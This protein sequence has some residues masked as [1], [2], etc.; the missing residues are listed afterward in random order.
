MYHCLNAYQ[1]EHSHGKVVLADLN[2][3]D[4]FRVSFGPCIPWLL[5]AFTTLGTPEGSE[6]EIDNNVAAAVLLGLPCHLADDD[7][8]LRRR[9]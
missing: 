5:V 8:L 6:V 9:V 4:A 2:A 7:K 1:Q 3:H